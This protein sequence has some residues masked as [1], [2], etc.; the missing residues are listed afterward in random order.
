MSVERS[1]NGRIPSHAGVPSPRE[2]T[3]LVLGGGGV[4]GAAW[5]MGALH[6]LREHTGWEPGRASHI[7]GTSAGSVVG[8]LLA[9][10]IPTGFLIR[11][12][13]GEHTDDV[14]VLGRP[15]ESAEE[16]TRGL[17]AWSGTIPRPILGSPCLALRTALTPWRFP[18]T[19]ALVGWIGRGFLSNAEVGHIIRSLVPEGWTEHPNLWLVAVDYSTGRRVVFGASDAREADLADAVR[20]SCAIP[21]F[22]EPVRI[23][24]RDYVDGGAWSPSNL[25]LL[26]HVDVDTVI[27]LNPM[28]S[29]HPGPPTT[30]L[31]RFER[32]I[33]SASGRRLGREARKLRDAGKRLLLIQP[34]ED[35]LKAMGVNLMNP[36]RR[37]HVLETAIHTTRQRLRE[38]DAR[39]VLDTVAV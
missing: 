27:A 32:R 39:A 25:D 11:H 29:L 5:L 37:V 1:G 19:A 7:V 6:A 36:T 3:G 10:G 9:I 15:V 24:G 14:L 12:Q 16:R 18:P 28:S 33:R 2:R 22:Y 21:G 8:A 20:A 38:P 35:D 30:I 4:L 17:F 13:R 26:T 31:E 34:R 23:D